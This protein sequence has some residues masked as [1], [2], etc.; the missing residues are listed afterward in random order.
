[1]NKAA[2]VRARLVMLGA[3]LA[4]GVPGVRA[5]PTGLNNI[6]TADTVPHRTVALQAFSSFGGANQFAAN[7]PG[8]HSF[9]LGMKTGWEFKPFSFEWGLDSPVAP[10]DAGALQYQA[11][12]NVSPWEG[13]RLAVG[14]ANVALTDQDRWSEP[15]TYAMVAHDF[16]V[17]RVHGGYGLQQN[18]NSMLFG[19][20]RT[21]KVAGRDLNLNADLVQVR[22]GDAWLPSVGAKYVLSKHVVL[23]S[24]VNFPDRGAVSF[25]AKAN[26]IFTF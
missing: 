16:G 4:A 21:W 24:W 26:L 19:V 9:W 25:I 8:R 6:P 15:F 11:K 22:D 18:G 3:V 20:D 5:T 12:A 1:M 14:V 13:G 2:G 17:V 7:G 10:G 23:E